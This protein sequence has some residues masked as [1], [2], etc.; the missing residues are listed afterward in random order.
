MPMSPHYKGS[1]C[2]KANDSTLLVLNREAVS[3]S[4]RIFAFCL[5]GVTRF[6]DSAVVIISQSPEAVTLRR[7]IINGSHLHHVSTYILCGLMPMSPHYKGSAC[8]KAN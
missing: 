4:D 5:R 2:P 6:G 7:I 3:S 8:P 1:A